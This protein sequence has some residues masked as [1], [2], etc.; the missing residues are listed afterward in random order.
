MGGLA[1]RGWARA[2]AVHGEPVAA[3][4]GPAQTA[5]KDHLI[6]R[7]AETGRPKTRPRLPKPPAPSI[8]AVRRAPR[9]HIAP[10]RNEPSGGEAPPGQHTDRP[11]QAAGA[12]SPGGAAAPAAPSLASAAGARR[13]RG[14]ERSA[15]PVR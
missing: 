4:S 15:R 11:H 3:P 8:A 7:Q 12:E 10:D 6:G 13:A 14:N 5:L 2:L 1:T 9:G